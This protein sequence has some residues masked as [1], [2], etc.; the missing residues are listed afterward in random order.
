MHR[1]YII[2]DNNA[3]SI[4]ILHAALSYAQWAKEVELADIKIVFPKALLAEIEY[5]ASEYDKK[6]RHTAKKEKGSTLTFKQ[7]CSQ[8]SKFIVYPPAGQLEKQL[9]SMM[10][11]FACW[12]YRQDA[13]G[14][15][16]LMQT[17][18]S[19][20]G[21]DPRV[22]FLQA[23]DN[24]GIFSRLYIKCMQHSGFRRDRKRLIGKDMADHA[25][26]EWC[27]DELEKNYPV[28]LLIV[29]NDQPLIQNLRDVYTAALQKHHDDPLSKECQHRAQ[30][31]DYMDHF[32][33]PAFA[34]HLLYELKGMDLTN[35][36]A[37][38]CTDLCHYLIENK[39][40]FG[41]KLYEE[42]L[43]EAANREL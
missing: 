20:M 27:H 3:V 14:A 15:C 11:E 5:G 9:T 13:K 39:K 33:Q 4:E 8:Y 7:A 37:Q 24:P 29:S 21:A 2:L 18:I 28:D 32:D 12:F 19:K 25:M 16:E 34:R 35:P 42:R 40:S 41:S 1:Q 22:D 31:M 23:L 38:T 26:V 43:Q 10:L 36:S 30:V 6:M 17:D